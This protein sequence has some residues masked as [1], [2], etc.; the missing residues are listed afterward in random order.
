MNLFVGI[1]KNEDNK[2]EKG[3]FCERKFH[4][5]LDVTEL[6]YYKDKKRGIMRVMAPLSVGSLGTCDHSLILI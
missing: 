1:P 2:Y 6:Y 3:M 5:S 4:S